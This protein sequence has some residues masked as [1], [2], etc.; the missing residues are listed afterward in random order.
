MISIGMRCVVVGLVAWFGL[1][2]YIGMRCVVG[3]LVAWLKE[4][5]ISIRIRCVVPVV[6]LLG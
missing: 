3:G 6:S 1:V 5:L 2:I 4:R